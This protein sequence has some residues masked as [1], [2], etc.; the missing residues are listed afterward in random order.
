MP[1]IKLLKDLQLTLRVGQ[2]LDLEDEQLRFVPKYFYEL[3]ADNDV[4]AEPEAKEKKAKE[5]A[6]AE[7][8]KLAEAEI[9][10]ETKG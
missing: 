1:K 8:K 5:K 3:E 10:K 9:S 7:A 6:E 4:E 2:V